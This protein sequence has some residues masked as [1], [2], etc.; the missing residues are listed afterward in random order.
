VAIAGATADQ[1]A[2]LGG[3]IISPPFETSVGESAILIDPFGA[4]FSSRIGP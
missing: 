1:A 3:R 4:E 2:Q